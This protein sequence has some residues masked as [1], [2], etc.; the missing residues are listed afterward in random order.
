MR[1][2]EPRLVPLK[3]GEFTPVQEEILKPFRASNSVH[4]VVRTLVRH[5]R[6][7]KAFFGW[8]SY[9]MLEKNALP[10]RE[11]EIMALRTGFNAKASYVWGRHV[12]IAKQCGLTDEEIEALKKPVSARQWSEVDAA[13]I[14]A[15]D[16]LTS[17][18]FIP[19][20]IWAVLEKNFNEEQLADIVW[21][22]GHFCMLGMFLNTMGVQLDADTPQDPDLDMTK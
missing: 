17:E 22:C 10:Y 16:A 13:L 2:K 9:V 1:L 8:A 14:R 4:N 21:V 11:R 5:P 20:D 19:D 3:D 12:V 15:A 18:F 7:Q 6:A